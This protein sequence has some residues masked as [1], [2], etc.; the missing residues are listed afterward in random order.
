[1]CNVHLQ[2][3]KLGIRFAVFENNQPKAHLRHWT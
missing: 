1:V 2:I 3:T